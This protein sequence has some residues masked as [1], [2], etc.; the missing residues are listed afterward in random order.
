VTGPA[1][2][3]D[4]RTAGGTRSVSRVIFLGPPG[5]GKGTQALRLAEVRK[6]LHLSTGDML[7]LER[8]ARTPLGVKAEG[9]MNAGKLVPDDLII[10][11]LLD[12]LSRPDA[13]AGWILDGFPRTLAQAEAL[14]R[15]LAEAGSALDRVVCFDVAEQVVVDRLSGRLTCSKC[16]AVYN[17]RSN[18]PQ[19]PG[20]C[21]RCGA[22]LAIR[23]DDRAEA[24]LNRMKVYQEQTAPLVGYY[25][26]LR[27]L[28]RLDA[29]REAEQVFVELLR[30]VS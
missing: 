29:G 21:D 9:Y 26:K 13:R 10:D 8:A 25:E 3:N 11:M 16:A 19:K 30:V 18:P 4:G 5:A 14:T 23:A 2:G 27:L 17:A 28:T 1:K 15:R 7:R 20:V 22:A 6:L 12:R 24:V